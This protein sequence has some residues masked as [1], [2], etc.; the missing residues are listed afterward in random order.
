MTPYARDFAERGLT[1]SPHEFYC[2][3]EM[4]GGVQ[5]KGKTTTNPLCNDPSGNAT[6][7]GVP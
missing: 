4:A 3:L 2:A 6:L 1:V 7:T 5:S